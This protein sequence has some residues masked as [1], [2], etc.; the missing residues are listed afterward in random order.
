MSLQTFQIKTL[1]MGRHLS[2][3]S[4]WRSKHYIIITF[5]NFDKHSLQ[6]LSHSPCLF[7]SSHNTYESPSFISHPRATLT[8]NSAVCCFYF[9]SINEFTDIC[10]CFII[11]LSKSIVYI[12]IDLKYKNPLA[13][14]RTWVHH[15]VIDIPEWAPGKLSVGRRG[16]IKCAMCLN[17]SYEKNF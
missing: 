14:I 8:I 16:N 5:S 3:N 6:V 4:P 11:N 9:P 15:I 12:A 1:T 17:E 10:N 2:R 13:L 7:L